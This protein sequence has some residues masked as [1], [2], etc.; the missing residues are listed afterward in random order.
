MSGGTSSARTILANGGWLVAAE[1][2]GRALTFLAI[3]HLSRALGPG[4][5]GMVELGLGVF[6]FLALIALGGVEVLAIRRTARTV[7]GLGRLATTHL[8][9]AWIWTLPALAIAIAML[10]RLDH[11]TPTAWIAGGVG[12]A[13]LI[14]PLGLRFAFQGRER[15]DGIA[16]G[17]LAGQATWTAA[18]LVVV[19]DPT[20]VQWIPGLWLAGEIARVSLMLTLFGRRF[21]PLR[22]TRAR[23]VRTWLLASGPISVGR[24]ARGLVYFVDVLAL[25]L[26]APLSVVGLYAVG[27]R[28]PLFLVH[29]TTLAN[30]AL[31]PS[32]ARVLRRSDDAGAAAL[33]ATFLPPVISLSLAAAIALAV[34][35]EAF[36]STLFGPAYGQAAPWMAVLLF[37]GPAAAVGGMFRMVL[38][39]R[40]PDEEAR[41]SVIATAVTLLLLAALVPIWSAAGAAT[42]ML[43]GELS[44]TL[45]YAR[46]ARPLLA[47]LPLIPSW[48]MLQSA[49]LIAL[50]G[51][52][53]WVQGRP[54][55]VVMSSAVLVGGTCGF[56]PLLPRLPE[57]MRGLR[58]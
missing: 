15:M 32:F 31:F 5:M 23:A 12:A 25:G 47:R 21:G 52:A 48:A 11:P 40:S 19:R 34:S 8:L 3:A 9:V 38:W 51:W 28:L 56:A 55:A 35:G 6:G 46:L 14:S 26:F 7:V 17:S 57:L 41:A 18:V 29:S 43:L 37:R 39:V 44:F 36:L 30:R 10:S 1:G 33:V 22:P 4:S 13:A 54:D 49:A 27:L 58:G 20:D 24:I 53:W 50:A 2:L 16:F 45:L 42:A